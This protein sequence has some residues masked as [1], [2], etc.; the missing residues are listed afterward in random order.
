MANKLG[1][2]K[3]RPMGGFFTMGDGP[4]AAFGPR[5]A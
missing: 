3:A 1:G 5:G 2:H 4:S